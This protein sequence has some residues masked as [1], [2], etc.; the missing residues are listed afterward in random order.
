L[1]N[2]KWEGVI[3]VELNQKVK[4]LEDQL[5]LVKN[6]VRE[7]LLDIRE[8]VLKLGNP[9]TRTGISPNEW[10]GELQ[11]QVAPDVQRTTPEPVE[12]QVRKITLE[13]EEGQVQKMTPEPEEAMP[14]AEKSGAKGS[15]TVQLDGQISPDRGLYPYPTPRF[16]QVE[17][18]NGE[19]PLFTIAAL[20]QWASKAT[21]RI[22]QERVEAILD[23]YQMTG[24]LSAQ[25]KQ[26][27]LRL[28][29]LGEGGEPESQ[30]TTK[31]CIAVLVELDGLLGQD[32]RPESALVS[33]LLNDLEAGDG[34]RLRRRPRK[35]G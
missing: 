6:E 27:A 20:T 23:V 19:V 2:I 24:R 18:R 15:E 3:P 29:C 22:G 34:R 31:D 30:V 11:Q 1:A 14:R 13:S 35:T 17:G 25:L 21:R 4:E 12:G 10:E 9:F 5:K 16:G 7:T 8:H 33:I 26:V 28:T 32:A